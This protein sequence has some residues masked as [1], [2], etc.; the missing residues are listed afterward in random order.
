MIGYKDHEI[1]NNFYEWKSRVHPDDL[2]SA[3]E[4]IQKSITD[5]EQNHKA[6]F[7][8]RHRDGSYRWILAQASILQDESGQAIRMLG[9]HV[10]ISERKKA[11]TELAEEKELLRAIFEQTGGYC[12]LLQP[13]D[14]G[15]PIILDANDAAC[16]SHSYTREE[17]IGRPVTDLDDEEGKKRCRERTKIIL[18]GKTLNVENK[19]VR[20]D[21]TTFPVE[22][23]ANIIRFK[24][25]PP[26]IVT[27]QFDI[28]DRRKAAEERLLLEKQL[29]QAQKMDSIGNLAGGIAHDFN[30]I[31]S[32]IIGFTELT[33]DEVDKGSIAEDNLRE[34]YSAGRRAKDLIQQILMFAR[35][36]EEKVK[37]IQVAPIVKEVLKFIKSSTPSTIEIKQEILSDSFI[38][39]N[40][41]QIHQIMMNLCTNASYAMGEEGGVLEIKLQDITIDEIQDRKNLNAKIENYMELRVSDTGPGIS[42]E[43]IG[44][45]FE[46]Y[47]TTKAPGEGTGMGLAMV[48]GIV[49]NYG[50]KITVNSRL[51]QGT[52]FTIYLPVTEKSGAQTLYDSEVLPPGTERILFVDDEISITKMGCRILGQLGYSV[53]PKTNSMDALELFRSKPEDFDL[54]ISDMTMPHMTGERLSTELMN[55]RADIPVILCTGYSKKMTAETAAT[56]PENGRNRTFDM[57]SGP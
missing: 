44:K 19:H 20:K 15:I 50:G 37:P 33:L 55:I 31:L 4:S 3:M 34:V 45:I 13:T 27:T 10:D 16:K 30:N 36:S 49:A 38:I 43:T 18:S 8:F 47:F 22:V 29:Q 32:A 9:S 11:E 21:G 25:K 40:P 2:E 54:V 52:I 48:H 51:D 28:S 39:G 53:T 46:P 23:F 41:S 35:Q 6:E 12:M 7:R 17:L 26:L 5:L 1:G 24:N 42:A 56:G 14:N 57:G